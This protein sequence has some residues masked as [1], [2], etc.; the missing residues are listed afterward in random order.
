MRSSSR[1]RLRSDRGLIVRAVLHEPIGRP[2]QTPTCHPRARLSGADVVTRI[3]EVDLDDAGGLELLWSELRRHR[4]IQTPT[5]SC[6]CRSSVAASV[7]RQRGRAH[8]RIPTRCTRPWR[9]S[10]GLPSLCQTGRHSGTIDGLGRRW[11]VSENVPT[12]TATRRK[13]S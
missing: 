3:R 13:A 8:S 6:D 7:F 10:P 2:S 11:P 4:A 12:R 5:P 9:A 1:P